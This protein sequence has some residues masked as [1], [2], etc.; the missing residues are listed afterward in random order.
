MLKIRKGKVL[1]DKKEKKKLVGN[2]M[3]SIY[4]EANIIEG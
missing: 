4:G 2:L 3:K 1:L